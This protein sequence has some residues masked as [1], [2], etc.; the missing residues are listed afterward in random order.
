[1]RNAFVSKKFSFSQAVQESMDKQRG[2]FAMKVIQKCK[3]QDLNR[4]QTPNQ[5]AAIKSPPNRLKND[6][7]PKDS[8]FI[9]DLQGLVQEETIHEPIKSNMFKITSKTL[10]QDLE[11]QP[12]HSYKNSAIGMYLSRRSLSTGTK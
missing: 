11:F 7:N 10:R 12:D 6:F 3:Q 4:S 8:F 1:M 9:E 5:K 2:Y